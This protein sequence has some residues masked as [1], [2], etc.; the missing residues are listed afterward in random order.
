MSKREK[1]RIFESDYVQER[2]D[3]DERIE[4]ERQREKG[5]GGVW[6][7]KERKMEGVRE[8]D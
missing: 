6:R 7:E 4:Q 2:F 1:R 5:G 3:G 8:R